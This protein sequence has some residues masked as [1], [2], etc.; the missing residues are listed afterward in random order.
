[1]KQRATFSYQLQLMLLSDALI[2]SI[3]GWRESDKD[4]SYLHFWKNDLRY[5]F[6][7][8]PTNKKTPMKKYRFH[9]SFLEQLLK[10]PFISIVS[11]RVGLHPFPQILRECFP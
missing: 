11:Q 7:V 5:S 6:T 8:F 10:D 2:C 1:M 3:V 4:I 9:R